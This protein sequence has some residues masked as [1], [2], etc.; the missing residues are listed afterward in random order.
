MSN[1]VHN[2]TLKTGIEVHRMRRPSRIVEELL[3]SVSPLMTPGVTTRQINA[4]CEDFIAGRKAE[5]SLKGYRGFPASICA[6]PNGVAVHGI[7]D[8][9][10]L[11]DGDIVTIDV[12]L[13]VDGWHGDGAW[14]YIVGKASPEKLHLLKAAWK[15][16]LAGILAAK[17]GGRLGDVGAAI[18]RAAKRQGCTVLED[19][20]GHGIGT[21]LHE[22]PIVANTGTRGTGQPIVPGMVFTVEP[23]LCI[24][25]PE[26]GV[27][28]DGWTV[29]TKDGSPTAQFE[30]TLAVFRDRT[31]ILTFTS[32]DL[33]ANID[34]PPFF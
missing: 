27:L 31:E 26:T 32:P 18:E 28:E 13:N 34:A 14:T 11:R 9:N 3:R 17:A 16:T 1:L 30:H 15:S 21:S 20:A 23:I 6:S 2:I 4:H 5:S 25:K 7:P 19:F 29:V 33:R 10:P 24:G 8:D 22:D 12:T